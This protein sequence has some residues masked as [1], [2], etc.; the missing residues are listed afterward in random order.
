MPQWL[1]LCVMWG[2]DFGPL[3]PGLPPPLPPFPLGPATTAPTD[4]PAATTLRMNLFMI[5]LPFLVSVGPC[6]PAYL[7]ERDRE[8]GVTGKFARTPIG[9]LTGMKRIQPAGDPT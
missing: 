1:L 9:R 2:G 7:V 5:S 3:P 6:C 4:S 8:R